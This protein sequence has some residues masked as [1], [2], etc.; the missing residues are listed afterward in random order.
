MDLE[1]GVNMLKDCIEIFKKQYD[2]KGDKLI[3]DNYIL[4]EGSYIL[5]DESGNISKFIEVGKKDFDRIQCS[6]FIEIDYLSK[7]IDMNKPIDGKKVIHSN[8]IFSFWLKKDS[9]R[10]DSKGNVKL[11]EDIIDNYYKILANPRLKYTKKKSLELYEELERSLGEP[12]IDKLNKNK[13]WI[14]ENI[15]DIID[16]QGLKNDKSY[17]KIFFEADIEEYKAESKRY[18]IP[19]IYNSTDYNLVL[20]EE[21]YGLPNDN[22]G[23]NS[24][25]PYLENKSRKNTI[26]YLIST[27]EVN[28]QKK[29]TDYLYNAA[30]DGK[31]N[32]YVSEEKV[33]AYKN[34]ENIDE[35]FTGYFLRIKKGKEVEIHDFD[36]ITKFNPNIKAIELKQV[37][38]VNKAL[39]KNAKEPLA[40]EKITKLKDVKA[41]INNIFFKKFLVPNYFSDAK[42]I[43][44]NDFRVKEELL[45]CRNGFFCCFYKG[46]STVIKAIFPK[47]SLNL[48]KNSIVNGEMARAIDQFNVRSALIGYFKGGEDM[49]DKLKTLND[50]LRVKINDKNTGFIE[51]DDE[52][53]FAVGQVANYLLSLNKSSKK[54]HSMVNPILNCKSSEKLKVEIEKIFRKYNYAID[55]NNKRF[56]NLSAMVLGYEA[57]G[58][59]NEDILVAGYLYSNL[60]YEKKEEN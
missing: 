36:I 27:D 15:Y 2:E 18:I 5:V 45:K 12:N 39:I 33:K 57:E 31:T 49:A 20:N 32:V 22:M 34:D 46:D 21:I 48:I 16:R 24:K 52:Y 8:N 23:L 53:F 1:G 7:L 11:S 38:P 42:D 6:D 19:N 26:P 25:K 28:L 60:I 14:K 59:I 50:K 55:R 30:C 3:T 44:I 51:S 9:I 10:P 17:L 13:Q 41:I 54:T 37:V 47:S 35:S 58:N 29:F 43:R 40:Y 56:N 4:S